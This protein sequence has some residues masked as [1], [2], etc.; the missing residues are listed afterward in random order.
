MIVLATLLVVAASRLVNCNLVS[1]EE[2][3]TVL[4]GATEVFARFAKFSECAKRALQLISEVRIGLKAG[5]ASCD[6]N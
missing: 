1:P 6:L 3:Q 5:T 4:D 2:M